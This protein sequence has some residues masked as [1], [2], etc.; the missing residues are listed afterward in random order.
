VAADGAGSA[1]VPVTPLRV[2]DSRVSQPL[3]P[4]Q[5]TQVSLTGQA[6]GVRTIGSGG[7]TSYLVK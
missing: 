2:L 3:A 6:T 1:Y 4:G 5:C 7:T